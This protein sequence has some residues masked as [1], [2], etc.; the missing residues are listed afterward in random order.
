M[1]TN[2]QGT[3]TRDFQTALHSPNIM[4]EIVHV[5][6]NL[7]EAGF[8]AWMNQNEMVSTFNN[9]FEFYEDD[10]LPLT[11]TTAATATAGAETINITTAL[12][13]IKGQLWQN[14]RT[15]EVIYV[16]S[17]NTSGGYIIAQ[18]GIGRDST[19][20]TGTAGTAMNSG[21]TLVR[22]GPSM[23]EI[24]RRQTF[25]STTPAQVFN[26]TEKMRWEIDMSDW[27]RATRHITGNDW[28]YQMD[29]TM[30]QARK[31]INGKLLYGERNS[32]ASLEGQQHYTTGGLDFYVSTNT[33]AF[34]GVVHE[35][36]LDA[37]LDES[38][39]RYGSKDKLWLGSV[40][41]NRA[42]VEI[43]K[44]YMSIERVNLGPP[45]V[46]VGVTV[47]AYHPPNGGRLIVMEDRFLS[48]AYSGTAFIVDTAVCRIRHFSGDDKDG[49]PHIKPNTQETDADNTAAAI[50]CDLGFEPGP[51]KHHAKMTGIT[52]GARGR[53]VS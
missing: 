38:A 25:Q 7:E 28:D 8:L 26:Y 15:G 40:K 52:G 46:E 51:E 20:S 53:P 37:F 31:D 13:Y 11:D 39:M 23:G 30:R 14:T 24:S 16:K 32:L 19:N 34:S 29:K 5:D 48:S 45:G 18:R 27:Q 49:R 47:R 9:K 33:K 1:A 21:D 35:Y 42:L 36:A 41:A 10:W 43:A 50:I 2:K 4:P 3:R 6:G 44:D 22:L 17:V 12:A